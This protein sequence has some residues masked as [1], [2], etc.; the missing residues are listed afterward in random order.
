MLTDE[1]RQYMLDDISSPL[2]AAAQKINLA[3][4]YQSLLM[5]FPNVRVTLTP[6]SVAR[7]SRLS[8]PSTLTLCAF[9]RGRGLL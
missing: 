6:E 7:S 2:I 1:Q 9:T 3:E 4:R 8:L 5:R